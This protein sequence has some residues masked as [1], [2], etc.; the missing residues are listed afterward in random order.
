MSCIKN[1]D[2]SMSIESFKRAFLDLDGIELDVQNFESPNSS[3]LNCSINIA[4]FHCVSFFRW[5]FYG[6]V[7]ACRSWKNKLVL[8]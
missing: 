3:Y 7:V 8:A 4:Y 2:L 6:R 1:I 5:I